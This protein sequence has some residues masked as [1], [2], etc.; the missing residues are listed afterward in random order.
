MASE[1]GI[2]RHLAKLDLTVNG[3]GT[4]GNPGLIRRVDRIEYKISS[5][6]KINWAIFLLLMGLFINVIYSLVKMP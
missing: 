5:V 1:K 6:M 4:E 2:E 3:D